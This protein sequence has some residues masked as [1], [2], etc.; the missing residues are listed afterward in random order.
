SIVAVDGRQVDPRTGPAP[1]LVGTAGKPVE[2]TV[3]PGGGGEPRRVV[4][5]PLE[6]EEPLR[7]HA[8]VGVRRAR[9]RE[10]SDGR[11]GYLL[12]PD[13]MGAG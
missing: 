13:L 10:L 6:D 4:V 11:V 9:V 1:L 12:V 2:L 7:Y 8:W 5:V 3:R